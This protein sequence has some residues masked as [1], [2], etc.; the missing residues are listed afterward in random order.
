[1]YGLYQVS[2]VGTDSMAFLYPKGATVINPDAIGIFKGA[3]NIQTAQRFIDFLLSTEG[4]SLWVQPRGKPG[5]PTKFEI[6][7]MSVRPD[8]YG[9]YPPGTGFLNPF[10]QPVRMH[11]DDGLAS[12]RRHVLQGLLGAT[13]IDPHSDLTKAWNKIRILPPG[14]RDTAIEQ[15]A[16][17][18]ISE[19]EL[20]SLAADWDNAVKRNKLI[21]HWQREAM[22]KYR[23]FL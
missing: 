15:F 22:Q 19:N 18:P 16:A 8:L 21:L 1:V 3:P 5:G 17:A 20:N 4:Q 14:Q 13:L 10:T 9:A 2:S 23:R 6:P 11:F 12:R 7:R